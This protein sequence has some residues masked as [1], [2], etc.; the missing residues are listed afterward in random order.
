MFLQV[1]LF[2][3]KA[4]RPKI[5]PSSSGSKSV[6]S[7]SAPSVPA[8]EEDP[9]PPAEEGTEASPPLVKARPL[10]AD[11]KRLGRLCTADLAGNKFVQAMKLPISGSNIIMFSF[12][13]LSIR[14]EGEYVLRYRVFDV[15]SVAAGS[16]PIPVLAECIGRPFRVYTT[17]EF[18]GLGPTTALTKVRLSGHSGKSPLDANWVRL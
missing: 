7:T 2:V 3:V 6:S 9:S 17:K 1:D 10:H 15:L 5:T 14:T 12:S 18:P 4:K 11:G 16:V 8:T 13:D